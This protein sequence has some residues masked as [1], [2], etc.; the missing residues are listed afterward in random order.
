MQARL[1]Y[2]CYTYVVF[3]ARERVFYIFI[4]I[5][6]EY[7]IYSLFI[8]CIWFII[9]N[10]QSMTIYIDWCISSIH[11]C[12]YFID[13]ASADSKKVEPEWK[14]KAAEKRERIISKD[15]SIWLNDLFKVMRKWPRQ[16]FL[17]KTW[18]NGILAKVRVENKWVGLLCKNVLW[19]MTVDIL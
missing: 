10:N 12:T 2:S 7:C 17:K 4:I 16:F 15:S 5:S 13:V 19:I 1:N 11:L 8:C 9:L 14:Q 6:Y 18:T 3:S